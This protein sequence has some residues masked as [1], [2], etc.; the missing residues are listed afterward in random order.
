MRKENLVE[1]LL[2]QYL[3]PVHDVDA[4]LGLA[5][6]SAGKVVDDIA[7]SGHLCLNLVSP[8]GLQRGASR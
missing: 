6:L 2:Y 1:R 8:H 7:G 3:F 5:D 4:M